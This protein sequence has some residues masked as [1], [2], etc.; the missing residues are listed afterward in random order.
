MRETAPLS[1]SITDHIATAI[2]ATVIGGVMVMSVTMTAMGT[3]TD[4]ALSS[5]SDAA[6]T[7]IMAI[8]AAM[9]GITVAATVG[10]AVTTELATPC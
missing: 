3:A 8:M 6:I 4:L 10:M 7:A 9:T 2:G 1:R 5:D